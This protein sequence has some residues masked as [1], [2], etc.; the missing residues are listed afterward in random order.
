MKFFFLFLAAFAG[1]NLSA[2]IVTDR[3]DQTES[4]ATVGAG[5]LQIETG[6]GFES[7]D[8]DKT[9]KSES[10][11]LPN[12]LFRLGLSERW[13]LRLVTQPE[14][15]REFTN[16]TLNSKRFGFADAQVGFKVNLVSGENRKTEVGFLAHLQVPTGTDLISNHDGGFISKLAITHTLNAKHSIAYNVGYDYLGMDNGDISYSLAWG[17]GLTGKVGVYAEVYGSLANL[18]ELQSNVDF[19]FTYLFTPNVQFDYSFGY[20]LSQEMNY[21]AIGVSLKLEK[22]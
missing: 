21:H 7:L 14:L 2:Q 12:T 3:P 9:G 20:G 8:V 10:W 22:G 19:G 4:S 1:Y 11:T 16:D 15:Q 13:E 5:V 18:E 6:F 17:I